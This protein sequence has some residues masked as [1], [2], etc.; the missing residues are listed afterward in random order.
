[1]AY[2]VGEVSKVLEAAARENADGGV[3]VEDA[4]PQVLR[5]TASRKR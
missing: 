3:G 2:L 5:A 4:A 1:M